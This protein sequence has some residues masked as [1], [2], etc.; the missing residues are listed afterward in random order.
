MRPV[1]LVVDA[2]SRDQLNLEIREGGE[3]VKVKVKTEPLPEISLRAISAGEGWPSDVRA[4][5]T[6]VGHPWPSDLVAVA[7]RLSPGAIRVLLDAGANWAD[8]AGEIRIVQ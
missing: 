7:S 2:L 6:E 4:V 8:T 5:L 1:D 3:V